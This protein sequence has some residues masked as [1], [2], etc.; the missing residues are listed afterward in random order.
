MESLHQQANL[1]VPKLRQYSVNALEKAAISL[2]VSGNAAMKAGDIKLAYVH[3]LK[4]TQMILQII[5][6]NKS[7]SPNFNSLQKMAGLDLSSCEILKKKILEQTSAYELKERVRKL[8]QVDTQK[9]VVEPAID[10]SVIHKN[11]LLSFPFSKSISLVELLPF[12]QSAT[13]TSLATILFI[14]ISAV[15]QSKPWMSFYIYLAPTP[16]NNKLQIMSALSVNHKPLFD[17]IGAF[18]IIAIYGDTINFTSTLHDTLFDLYP[19]LNICILRGSL[20][21]IDIKIP[22]RDALP[23]PTPIASTPMTISSIFDDPNFNFTTKQLPKLPTLK[24]S[25]QPSTVKKQVSFQLPPSK[26]PVPV[27]PTQPTVSSQIFPINTKSSSSATAVGLK[28]LG[29]TCYMN[30]SLQVMKATLPLN[31]YFTTGQFKQH[32]NLSNKLGYSG[33]LATSVF[34]V[35]KD[36]SST[37]YFTTT[38][39]PREF[40]MQIGGYND[41]FHGN[42]QHDASEFI[43]WILDGLHEE[44]K[45]DNGQSIISQL[46][47]GQLASNLQCETCHHISTTTHATSMLSVP[48]VNKTGC[49][50]NQCISEFLKSEKLEGENKWECPNCKIKRNATKTLQLVTLPEVLIIHLKRFE[51]IGTFREKLGGKVQFNGYNLEMKNAQGKLENYDLY[52]IIYQFGGLDSGHYTSACKYVDKWYYFDDSRISDYSEDEFDYKAAYVLFYVKS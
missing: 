31:R 7:I 41:M 26:A 46:F 52:G 22:P 50:V 47:H 14:N 32:L 23:T 12:I 17:T 9:H 43:N 34:K 27:N 29:N 24:P 49:S 11:P 33:K 20:D 2:S 8:L 18:D 45:Q 28:N 1:D 19:T 42:E 37:E 40:K 13:S 10:V 25:K 4:S 48:I 21:N 44:G 15:D 39:N 30:A 5:P 3:L 16:Y 35:L 36:M 38:Y 6:L 51:Y